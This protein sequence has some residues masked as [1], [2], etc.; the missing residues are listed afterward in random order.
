M[1][2]LP[3]PLPAPAPAPD[4]PVAL[5]LGDQWHTKVMQLCRQGTVMALVREL[6][7]QSGLVAIDHSAD[8]ACWRLCVERES[9]RSP[10]LRDKLASALA[11]ELG[12]AVDLVVEV[13]VPADSPA[14]REAAE[15]DRRQ[16]AAEAS[17]RQDPLVR[18]LLNQYKG[19]RIVPGSIK[20]FPAPS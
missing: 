12:H 2:P 1:A 3:E 15:R 17:I 11:T 8:P 19:A 14:L 18:E 5:A 20:P 4:G 16:A 9:L 6:A 10:A 13:G 7:L